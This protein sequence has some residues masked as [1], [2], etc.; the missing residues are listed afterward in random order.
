MHAQVRVIRGWLRATALV[1]IVALGASHAWADL[2]IA[3]PV[4]PV[5]LPFP[6][7]AAR[8]H[9]DVVLELVIGTEGTVESAEFRA[10]QPPDAPDTFAERAL[11]VSKATRFHPTM[12]NGLP[13]R[14]RIN[15]VV[16]FDPPAKA[17]KLK[18]VE[19]RRPNDSGVVE[20][21]VALEPSRESSVSAIP[22]RGPSDEVTIQGAGWYS[23]RGIA[24][25]RV[26]RRLIDAAP[27]QQSSEMLSAAPG[28][29]VDHEDGEGMGN[30]VYLRGFDLEHGSGIEML[31]NS[32]PINVP[33]HVNGQGYADANFVIPEV[34]RSIHVK[35]GPFDPR[36]GDAAIVGSAQ[37]DLGVTERGY[38]FKTSYGSFNQARVF[39]VIAPRGAVD[40]TF[41]AFSLRKSDGFGQRRAGH[42]MTVNSQHE[43]RLGARETVRLLAAAYRA[44]SELPGV[45]RADDIQA[46]HLGLYDSYASYA[47]NQGVG[48]SR[49]LLAAEWW[50]QAP[51]G[52]KT[53]VAPFVTWTDFSARQ[54]FTG[55]LLQ[56]QR[57]PGSPPRG[58]LF[59][60]GN[61]ELAAG[62][63]TVHQPAS[64]NLGKGVEARAEPGLFY[65]AGRT[66]QTRSLIDAVTLQPWERRLD[67][68]LTTLDFAGYLDINIRF[69]KR[70]RVSGGPRA[71]L[72]LVS[73]D[74]RLATAVSGGDAS[75]GARRRQAV[76]V[77]PSLRA[78]AEYSLLPGLAIS[79]SYGQGFR[80]LP[81]DLMNGRSRPFSLV[82]SVEAGL[83]LVALSGRLSARLAAFESWVDNELVFEAES[84]G[85]EIQNR[86][87]RV[88]GVAS[89]LAEPSDWLLISSALSIARAEYT[90]RETGDER[91][92]PSVPAYLLRSDVTLHGNLAK[93]GSSP[94]VA[95]FATGYTVLGGRHVSDTE[96]LPTDV[97]INASSSLRYR[98][99]EL[100]IEAYNVLGLK[101]A[102]EA[103]VFASNW[104]WNSTP[105]PASVMRHSVAAA[106][107][108]I[109][110]TASVYF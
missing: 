80:S 90:V 47:G 31:V 61:E 89:F 50:H 107:R 4:V 53:T 65:R 87:T 104:G 85:L 73:I 39:G 56:A 97:V 69:W 51:S 58:D 64:I 46:R 96:V 110:G 12:Q 1:L 49:L 19:Q 60:S 37:Y 55:T 105:Q 66:E 83:R 23:P 14:S 54:N 103:Q 52:V 70:L 17:T 62:I 95:R 94:L 88:G 92:V 40:E 98:S 30:D 34:V 93:V 7:G 6:E 26:D 35:E 13:I 16:S 109:I 78:T 41:T 71:D 15:F 57:M 74:D 33:L 3:A 59:N 79:T 24:D 63:S 20:S 75:P 86:S 67:N 27:R 2:I 28:F 91:A 44:E 25:L 72:L 5:R 101:Y 10:M 22:R 43:W 8:I 45:V 82:R 42:S 11:A 29:F 9:V 36:Q 108:T 68:R 100:G 77:A 106:P 99:L 32:M 21:P 48:S 18:R 81:A 102:D 76:G 38:R 84:G